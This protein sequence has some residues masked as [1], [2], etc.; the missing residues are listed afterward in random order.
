MKKI[1]KMADF[2][3]QL[4]D[5]LLLVLELECHDPV[6]FTTSHTVVFFL[7][8]SKQFKQNTCNIQFIKSF[9]LKYGISNG[10]TN[11]LYILFSAS[12]SFHHSFNISRF[13][14][15]NLCGFCPILIKFAPH[16]NH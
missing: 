6:S 15:N 9:H 5:V 12:L 13:L 10:T 4:A 14:L 11:K 8:L 16:I 2:Q 7:N 1:F 3:E